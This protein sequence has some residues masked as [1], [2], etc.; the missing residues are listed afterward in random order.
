[1]KNKEYYFAGHSFFFIN[2]IFSVVFYRERLFADSAFY[3]F[4]ILN[5]QDFFIVHGRYSAVLMQFP[6]LLAS[7]LNLKLT[8]LAIIFSLTYSFYYYIIYIIISHILKKPILALTIPFLLTLAVQHTFYWPVSE[9]SLSLVAVVLVYALIE[10]N[11]PL[12]PSLARRRNFERSEKWGGSYFLNY[13]LIIITSIFSI[14][15]HPASVLALFYIFLFDVLSKKRISTDV[16]MGFV[17]SFLSLIVKLVFLNDNYES[18]Q[19]HFFLNITDP[20]YLLQLIFYFSYQKLLLTISV[21]AAVIF[22]IKMK[23][24]PKLTLLILFFIAYILF[25]NLFFAAVYDNFYIENLYLALSLFIVLPILVDVLPNI[26]NTNLKII[27]I[28]ILFLF[29]FI[30]I[31]ST[32]NIYKDRID[33]ML[34]IASKAN[35]ENQHKIIIDNDNING[36]TGNWSLPVESLVQTSIEGN[37]V[38]IVTQKVFNETS[39]KFSIDEHSIILSPWN[40]ITDTILNSRYFKLSEEQYR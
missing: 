13:F 4:S 2:I 17:A 34:G 27:L 9:Y 1:M 37:P 8:P 24:W 38:S 20:V 36:M 21:I 23:C 10:K 12:I 25:V 19:L 32:S 6:A 40:V 11:H 26:K 5:F 33:Y 22:Y 30:N 29:S 16:I 18:G 15:C 31:Y 14:F 35:F 3:F 39:T 7:L 28:S